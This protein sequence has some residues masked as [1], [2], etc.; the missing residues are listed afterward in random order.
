MGIGFQRW[1]G[2]L[3]KSTQPTIASLSSSL[4]GTSGQQTLTA[5]RSLSRQSLLLCIFD[6]L[7][8]WRETNRAA[9]NICV[10]HLMSL[11][12]ADDLSML[13]MHSASHDPPP[14]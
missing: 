1:L 4:Q 9:V 2:K 8:G 14:E 7:P 6:R 10:W 11:V 3:Y 5:R 13:S 12:S